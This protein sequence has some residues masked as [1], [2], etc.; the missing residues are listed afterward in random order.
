MKAYNLDR[1]ENRSVSASLQALM[2]QF[3]FSAIPEEAVARIAVPTSLIWG[4]HDS[5]VPLSVGQSASA[6]YG[7]PLQ[8][9]ENAGNEPAIEQPQAFLRALRTAIEAPTREQVVS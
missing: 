2:E 7:W 8:V 4:R 9:I 6:R 1:A 3:G 5:I